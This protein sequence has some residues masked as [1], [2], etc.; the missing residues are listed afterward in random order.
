MKKPVL[1]KLKQ[2]F[3]CRKEV[4][5]IIR[6]SVST[7]SQDRE[8]HVNA[9]FHPLCLECMCHQLN[10]IIYKQGGIGIGI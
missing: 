10:R 7:V 4:H 5:T 2:C 8:N 1:K 3:A 9:T 6:A